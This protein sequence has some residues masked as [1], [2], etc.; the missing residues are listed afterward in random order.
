MKE[1]T[2]P[3]ETLSMGARD[4]LGDILHQGAR[5]MLSKAIEGE[6]QAYIMDHQDCRDTNG[7]RQVV[8]N[9]YLPRRAIQTP[10]GEVTVT[11]P[12]VNDKRIDAEGQR[13]KFTS[14]IL[15]PYLRRTK[16]MEELLPWLYLKGISTG[17]FSEALQALLGPDAPGLSAS[18]IV[19]Q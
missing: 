2:T 19:R 8:R 6:V 16:S 5:D 12:R 17:D 18:T 3:N 10:V 9:G 7:C 11:Q 15:P 13:I 4:V 1:T 14:Q